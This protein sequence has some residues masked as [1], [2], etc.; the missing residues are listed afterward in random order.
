MSFRIRN[1]GRFDTVTTKKTSSGTAIIDTVTSDNY[2]YGKIGETGVD[3]V[4]WNDLSFKMSSYPTSFISDFRLVLEKSPTLNIGTLKRMGMDAAGPVFQ[5]YEKSFTY[6]VIPDATVL[7]APPNIWDTRYSSGITGVGTLIA[8]SIVNQGQIG[9]CYANSVQGCLSCNMSVELATIGEPLANI[10]SIVNNLRPSRSFLEYAYKRTFD[11]L[12]NET[13]FSQGGFPVLAALS[14]SSSGIPLE[15][16]YAYPALYADLSDVG[17]TVEEFQELV[18]EAF[19]KL[20]TPPNGDILLLA[21]NSSWKDTTWVSAGFE[22]DTLTTIDLYK[23]STDRI[24]RLESLISEGYTI[25]ACIDIFE[26]FVVNVGIIPFPPTGL[27]IGGHAVCIVGYDRN[28]AEYGPSFL[29][30]NSWGS[31]I[32][33]E[34]YY[35]FPY[36]WIGYLMTSYPFFLANWG[37]AINPSWTTGQT[38]LGYGSISKPI[39]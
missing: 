3:G 16:E 5:Q 6:R 24:E 33:N 39:A 11:F 29:V 23:S 18:K 13:V 27:Y 32:G 31:D 9:S 26:N 10:E 15:T 35:W 7:P 1:D 14:V 19:Q 28:Q 17:F 25:S 36:G 12:R 38:L 30:R 2:L 8:P 21:Q 34:G 37:I 20:V 22:L 4:F